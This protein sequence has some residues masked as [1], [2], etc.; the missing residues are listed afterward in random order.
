MLTH[1]QKKKL[2]SLA[3]EG[4]AA[5][6]GKSSRNNNNHQGERTREDSTVA[7]GIVEGH[8]FSALL[9]VFQGVCVCVYESDLTRWHFCLFAFALFR[10][11]PFCLSDAEKL[12]LNL[13]LNRNQKL[14]KKSEFMATFFGLD[15]LAVNKG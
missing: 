12:N 13:S 11:L 3:H 5:A 7:A 6:E 2:A 10:L 15:F 9:R 8:D 1:C 4:S 14:K